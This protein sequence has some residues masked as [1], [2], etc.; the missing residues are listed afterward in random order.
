MS[1]QG[2]SNVRRSTA[3]ETR[4]PTA[5]KK[6]DVAAK[7]STTEEIIQTSF[8]MPRSRWK[9]LQELAIDQRVS[10]QSI[11]LVALEGEFAKRGLKF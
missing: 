2:V 9:K 7:Q 5:G 11:I 10:V 4:G 3:G 1:R 8:R 6:H